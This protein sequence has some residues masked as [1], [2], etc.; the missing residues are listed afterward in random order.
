[1]VQPSTEYKT[2]EDYFEESNSIELLSA[3]IP[4]TCDAQ[5]HD[6]KSI[7]ETKLAMEVSLVLQGLSFAMCDLHLYCVFSVFR[8]ALLS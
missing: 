1:M 7:L 2:W 4:V 6:S 8:F 5:H 3:H